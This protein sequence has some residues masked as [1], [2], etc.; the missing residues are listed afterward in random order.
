MK[1]ANKPSRKSISSPIVRAGIKKWSVDSL[2]TWKGSSK[3][4]VTMENFRTGLLSSSR[5]SAETRLDVGAHQ[6]D[7]FTIFPLSGP[8]TKR[9]LVFYYRC[10][11]RNCRCDLKLKKRN[12]TIFLYSQ[13]LLNS[14]ILTLGYFQ[15]SLK[16]F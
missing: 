8:W 13:Y 4:H 15:A 7:F 5:A 12:I 14:N 1:Q 3:H 10:V 16:M 11:W 2:Q 6:N 9:F